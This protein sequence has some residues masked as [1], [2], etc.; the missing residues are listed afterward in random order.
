MAA[1]TTTIIGGLLLG[2]LLA[3]SITGQRQAKKDA[4]KQMEETNARQDKLLA[5]ERTR[6]AQGESTEQALLAKARQKNAGGGGGRADTVLTSP[7]GLVGGTPAGVPTK[8]LL[9]V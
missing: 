1:A 7:L 3:E 9:G 6:E 4:K 8:T 5:D 2:G